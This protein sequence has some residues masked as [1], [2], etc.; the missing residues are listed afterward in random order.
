MRAGATRMNSMAVILLAS[1]TLTMKAAG[2]PSQAGNVE[3]KAQGRHPSGLMA[4]ITLPDGAS[5]TVKIEGVGCSLS[6]CSRV[7]IKGKNEG[8]S[9]VPRRLDSIEAIKDTTDG[10]ALL[11]LKDGTR[12]RLSLV[13]DFRVLYFET[14]SG[15]TEK[16][17]LAEV[18][19][20]EFV[21]PARS[22]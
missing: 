5:R 18:K 3:Q 1:I 15:R 6:I 19:S 20:I 10:D 11:V 14:Q 12:Q 22:Q 13:R 21:A 8:E 2:G 7:V 4:R 16:L 17:D 9:L